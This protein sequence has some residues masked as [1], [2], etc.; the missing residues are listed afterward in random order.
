[1]QD[2]DLT[3]TT[4][5]SGVYIN[6]PSQASSRIQPTDFVETPSPDLASPHLSFSNLIE[7]DSFSE[8][9]PG[10]LNREISLTESNR[11]ARIAEGWRP[12]IIYP[13]P[14]AARPDTRLELDAAP[15]EAAALSRAERPPTVLDIL[16][17][18]RLEDTRCPESSQK[19]GSSSPR[20]HT[21]KQPRNRSSGVYQSKKCSPHHS[22]W[23]E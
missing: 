14:L 2:A 4:L 8:S 16:E 22:H 3:W 6:Q 18:G 17:T 19:H 13:L 23:C 1:M 5:N 10:Q 11:E 15:P 12:G 7:R 20:R 9:P 21:R